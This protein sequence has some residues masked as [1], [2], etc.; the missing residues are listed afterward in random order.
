MTES[1]EKSNETPKFPRLKNENGRNNYNEWKVKAK[2][3]L[4]DMD[5]LDVVTKP[6]PITPKLRADQKVMV[7]IE[8]KLMEAVM[9]GNK[10][11]VERFESEN[12]DWVKRNK[13]AL[14]WIVNSVDAS[15][16]PLVSRCTT[17]KEAWDNLH[18]EFVPSNVLRSSTIRRQMLGYRCDADMNVSDWINNMRNLYDQLLEIDETKMT[19]EDFGQ[20][21]LDLLPLTST[22]RNFLSGHREQFSKGTKSRI[23]IEAIKSEWFAVHQ[24]D[25][26]VMAEIYSA[27]SASAKKRQSDQTSTKQ[28]KKQR[29][30]E[31]RQSTNN[32]CTNCKRIGHTFQKCYWE[33][34]GDEGNFPPSWKILPEWAKKLKAKRE[35][36]AGANQSTSSSLVERISSPNQD[37]V[38]PSP[39]V[40]LTLLSDYHVWSLEESDT[41]NNSPE[42]K[43]PVVNMSVSKT[44]HFFH[45]SGANR[46]IVHDRNLFDTY[47]HCEPI[48]VSAFG[49]KLSTHAV[50]YG[51][52]NLKSRV[53]EVTY[54]ITLRNVLHI[55]AARSNLV[56]QIQLDKAGITA[57]LKDGKIELLKENRVVI[58]GWVEREMYRLALEVVQ[59]TRKPT[60]A[61]VHTIKTSPNFCI[62]SWATPV[63]MA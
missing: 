59:P 26:E 23:I 14:R 39:S 11:E 50:G 45:D 54:N 62:A 13:T 41:S 8:G 5:L 44:N 48:K 21:L 38:S 29:I 43:L 33:N 16:M 18:T 22:W 60:N 15:Y 1:G 31:P 40:N 57:T 20:I 32:W 49:D 35:S 4:N 34:G 47:R 61:C 58:R 37:S 3:A 7:Q 36:R 42:C 51:M 27:R 46:H 6:A 55:P 10:E 63:K 2:S 19:D 25:D 28:A 24:D 9:P 52:V 17:A 53:G 12:K 56:S 30:T